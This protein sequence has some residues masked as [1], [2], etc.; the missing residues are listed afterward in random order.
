MTRTGTKPPKN[1][2][3]DYHV[4]LFKED[5]GYLK[6]RAQERGLPWQVFLRLMVRESVKA[7]KAG[8]SIMRDLA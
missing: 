5:V 2:I 1:A 7:S 3:H 8:I 6:E 4:R